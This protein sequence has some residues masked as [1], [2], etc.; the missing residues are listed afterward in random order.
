MSIPPRISRSSNNWSN[1][2]SLNAETGNLGPLIHSGLEVDTR[3]EGK[4]VDNTGHDAKQVYVDNGIQLAPDSTAEVVVTEK[5]EDEY[6]YPRAKRRICGLSAT[7]FWIIAAFLL[8]AII[9]GVL[10]GALMSTVGKKKT[11]SPSSPG[12]P[13]LPAAGNSSTPAN[14]SSSPQGSQS[15]S[16]VAAVSF[17]HIPAPQVENWMVFSQ[18]NVTGLL[19]LSFWSGS[20]WGVTVLNDATQLNPKAGTPISAGAYWDDLGMVCDFPL[21]TLLETR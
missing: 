3:Y 18:D 4:E 2:A 13:S 8:I 7:V 11:S 12:N 20:E 21:L 15:Y 1:Q 17:T 19:M 14:N 16:S 9:A 10:A 6:K 5:P